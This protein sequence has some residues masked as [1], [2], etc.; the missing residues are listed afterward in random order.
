M[1]VPDLKK[2]TNGHFNRVKLEILF[3]L[4]KNKEIKLYYYKK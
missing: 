3:Y 1:A 4:I 2:K